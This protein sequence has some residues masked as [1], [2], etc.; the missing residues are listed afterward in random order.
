M[1]IAKQLPCEYPVFSSYHYQISGMI[2]ALIN[3]SGYNW[4]INECV[5]LSCSDMFFSE[6]DTDGLMIDNSSFTENP[7]LDVCVLDEIGDWES[8]I[9]RIKSEIVE[10]RYVYFCGADDYYIAGKSN[11]GIYHMS[12]DGLIYGFNDKECELSVLAYN[13][14]WVC[15]PFTVSYSAFENS[16]HNILNGKKKW[17]GFFSFI[18]SKKDYIP[19][20]LFRIKTELCDYLNSDLKKYPFT[21][22]GK[23]S[24]IVVYDYLC[25]LF[26]LV[27][28]GYISPEGLDWRL[29]RVLWEHKKCMHDRIKTVI[30]LTGGDRSV[31]CD[32]EKV[33]NKANHARMIFARYCLRPDVSLLN[34]IS[35]ELHTI[36]STE[37]ELLTTV[38][39][40]LS[41]AL[42]GL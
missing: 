25:K 38:E 26:E 11:Y 33:V 3:P 31:C 18:K 39:S 29:M 23:K 16:L 9:A 32:Y 5:G 21:S 37:K 15:K 20:D 41:K 22:N 7:N 13:K 12:H 35:A 10:D 28:E 19:I 30:E 24:G 42:Q 40:G 8:V 36:K 34:S 27:S 1:S 6:S 17:Y 4:Y 2:P 14:D